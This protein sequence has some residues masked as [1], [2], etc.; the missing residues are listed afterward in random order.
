MHWI[1]RSCAC[2]RRPHRA[3]G[4]LDAVIDTADQ[5]DAAAVLLD[6][7]GIA[8]LQALVGYS[9]GAAVALQFAARHPGR[10]ERLVAVS[11]AHRAHPSAAAWRALQRKAVA[12]GELQCAGDQGLA[13]A[14]QFA[15]LGYRSGDGFAA[16][17]DGP[18][19]VANG[20]VRV[21]AKT[22][23][24]G[25]ARASLPGTGAGLAAAVGIA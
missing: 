21:A 23:W 10:L 24:S 5:A 8:R 19:E 6:T 2:S 20:R 3:D 1:R 17:F 7:L 9:Y 25:G 11:G 15:M 13:L 4:T 22:I 16:R 12:L 18:A 14:R